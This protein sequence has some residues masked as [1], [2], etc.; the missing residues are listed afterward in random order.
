MAARTD[1]VPARVE[2]AVTRLGPLAAFAYVAVSLATIVGG[3]GLAQW[4]DLTTNALSDLGRAGR[5]T[6]PIFNGGLILGGA[7][8]AVVGVWLATAR[9]GV[10]RVAG[11]AVALTMCL[12]IGI[13][14]FPVGTPLHAPFAIS[15]FVGL[16]VSLWLVGLGAL[17][18]GASGAT[19]AGDAD[20][21]PAARF[22]GGAILPLAA[23]TLVPVVWLSWGFGWASIAP[24]LALPE[25]FS[26]LGVL[27][28]FTQLARRNLSS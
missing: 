14:L 20:E 3:V 28:W 22:S 15:Y 1:S 5:L 24:G 13:G 10:G 6:A 17:R 7:L 8:G 21:P 27:L 12:R 2:R 23:G 25:I 11:V 18:T 26:S 4:F 9:T 16:A 19:D